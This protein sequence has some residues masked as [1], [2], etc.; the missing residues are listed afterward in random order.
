[1]C[2]DAYRFL[3]VS[4]RLGALSGGELCRDAID[5]SGQRFAHIVDKS[6]KATQTAVYLDCVKPRKDYANGSY[7][8]IDWLKVSEAW[9][10]ATFSRLPPES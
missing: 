10:Y 4:S 3:S 1:M 7:V 2:C 9:H 8:P 6:V 5:R